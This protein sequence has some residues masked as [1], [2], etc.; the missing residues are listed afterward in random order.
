MEEDRR[1]RWENFYKAPQMHKCYLYRALAGMVLCMLYSSEIEAQILRGRVVDQDT[2]E[3]LP[4]A[5]VQI[6]GTYRGTITN[7]AGMYAIAVEDMPVNIIVRYIGF[8]TDTLTAYTLT[9]LEFRLRPVAF[10]MEQMIVTDEDPA[11]RIMQQVIDRKRVWKQKLHTFEAQAYTRYTF[12]ND[13]GI[14]AIVESA[15]TAW[16]DKDHG[17]REEIK[18]TRSTG[19]VPF[20]EELPAASIVLN[21]Y[22][23]DIEIMGHTLMGVTHP[24]AMDM[25]IFTLDGTRKVDDMRI[26]D[27]AVQP[28]LRYTSGFVGRVS[29]VDSV[30]ALMEA[31]LQPGPAF[32]FPF[33]IQNYK[34]TYLQQFSDYGGEFWLP[35]DL[36][37]ETKVDVSLGALLS[38]PTFQINTVSRFTDY[39][40]NVSLSD[41]LFEGDDWLQVDSIAVS[42]GESFQREG[43]IVPLT[44]KE[45]VA[46]ASIDSTY[47]LE[48]AYEPEGTI[49]HILNRRREVEK[50]SSSMQKVLSFLTEHGIRPHIWYNRVDALHG[51]FEYRKDL[52]ETWKIEVHAGLNSGQSGAAKTAYKG[53]VRAGKEWFIEAG[54][55]AQNALTYESM[56]KGRLSNSGLMLL[57]KNDYFDYYR[58][59]GI[60]I[61]GGHRLRWQS[62]TVTTT[63]VH[64]KHSPLIGNISYDLLGSRVPQRPNVW[65]SEGDMRT[66]TF[67]FRVGRN[68]R[69]KLGPS[70]YFESSMEVSVPSSDY[71]FRRYHISVGGRINT[72]LQRRLLPA[73]LDYGIAM[74]MA[75]NGGRTLPPQ[76]SFIIEGSTTAYHWTGALHTL[77]GLP[78]QGNRFFFGH[79]EHNF[80]TLPFERLGWHSLVRG[81][82]SILLFGGHAFIQ[83]RP[84]NQWTHHN[85]FGLSL[86]GLFG[87]MRLNFAYRI[88][89]SRITPSVSVARFF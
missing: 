81:G 89:G 71:S 26:Y 28:K 32:L 10:E 41:S 43:A 3:A 49:G 59:A 76:R 50:Q 78:Y 7:N 64:E 1:K 48:E 72:F 16:W 69:L 84:Q 27:I 36:H 58:R 73:A 61:T 24:D 82:Y 62:A 52:G 57:G 15:A 53:S 83:R 65:I 80:R 51:G 21:L 9:P 60:F 63:Y 87:I 40:L 2:G 34:V 25:Y 5:T 54:Y 56:T 42:S 77:Y 70:R 74:G 85:E 19:N 14:V 45:T 68:Q 75:S 31:R 11:I 35:L 44:P 55:R 67:A 39:R 13:S 29:V 8:R 18:G 30:F 22:D 46:Y 12:S 23:D 20:G 6:E 66:I 37:S 88:G 38:F 33:P 86:S 47:S 4:A 17:L 79:W